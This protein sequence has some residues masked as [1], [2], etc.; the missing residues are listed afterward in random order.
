V[1]GEGD[2][3]ARLLVIGEAPGHDED[4]AGRPFVGRAGKILDSALSSAGIGS[5]Q[6]VFITN[7]VKCRPPG[8][9]RPTKAEAEKCTQEYLMR[10]IDALKPEII[11]LLGKTASGTLLGE[12][13]IRRIPSDWAGKDGQQYISTYHPAALLYNPR[14]KEIFE[15]DIREAVSRLSRKRSGNDIQ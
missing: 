15:H 5:R 14:L 10:Q 9:R 4:L 13:A 3:R 2:T 8:N 1:P 6:E 12:G 7:I 11:L